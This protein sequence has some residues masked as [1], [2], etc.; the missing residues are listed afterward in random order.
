M[1]IES[2]LIISLLVIPMLTI[3]ALI[4]IGK[5]PKIKRYVA[6]SGTAI[7]LIFAFINLKNV[8]QHW[9][10]KLELGSWDA[11]YSIVFVLD[12]FSGLLVITSLIVT[13]LIFFFSSQSLVI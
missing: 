1:M 9:P 13:M 7:T 8:L 10:I 3:I 11:P 4:I 12:I 2:N 6:L 5:R